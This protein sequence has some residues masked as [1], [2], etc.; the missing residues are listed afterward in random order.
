MYKDTIIPILV[1]GVL[2][3][4]GFW[5]YNEFLKPDTWYLNY[6]NN[7]NSVVNAGTYDSKDEC[8]LRLN[9]AKRQPSDYRE[10]ECGSNCDPPSVLGGSYVCD[11]TFEL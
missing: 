10:P 5:V 6:I 7:N 3:I 9:E 2:I 11:E 4:G 8:R 1:G